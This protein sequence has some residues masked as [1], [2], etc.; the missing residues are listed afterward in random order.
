M[1]KNNARIVFAICCCVLVKL[2]S[3][4]LANDKIGRVLWFTYFIGRLKMQQ[5]LTD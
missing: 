4:E 5:K 3:Y 2:I 1:K